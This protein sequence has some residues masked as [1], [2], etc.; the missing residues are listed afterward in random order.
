MENSWELQKWQAELSNFFVY[1]REVCD[2]TVFR[3][4]LEGKEDVDDGQWYFTSQESFLLDLSP[5]DGLQRE[6]QEI[7][8]W[9]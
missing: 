7:P 5:P 6:D 2:S 9:H 4:F 1:D 3:V 8:C